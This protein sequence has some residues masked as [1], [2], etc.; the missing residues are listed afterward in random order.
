N[1]V[2]FGNV[3]PTMRIAREEIFG[4]ILSVLSW[5]DY[6]EMMEIANGLDYGLTAVVMTNDLKNALRTADALQVGYV[7]V[8]GTVS[9]SPGAPFGGVK[10]SGF[11]REGGIEEL[12]SY[13]RTKAI[14]IRVDY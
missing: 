8:N 11:G 1:P 13:T 12:M 14:N 9:H 2:L 4:P 7:E 5:S 3:D 10:M 6:A